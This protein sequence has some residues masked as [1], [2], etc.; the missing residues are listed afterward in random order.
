[1]AAE[2]Q[3]HRAE[4]YLTSNSNNLPEGELT[5]YLYD[6]D[7]RHQKIGFMEGEFFAQPN[8]KVFRMEE[9]RIEDPDNRGGGTGQ[10]MVNAVMKF[11]NVLGLQKIEL[12]AGRE[13]GP[14]FWTHQGYQVETTG[15]LGNR[16]ADAVRENLEALPEEKREPIR[17]DVER[18]LENVHP[19]MN[20]ELLAIDPKGV[21]REL[22]SNTNPRMFF[23]LET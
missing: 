7:D 3:P 22:L 10:K 4:I 23:E 14:S 12:R 1:M 13:N 15:V 9:I 19:A 16:F 18:I 11:C 2:M 8:Q 20:Q 21:G 6:A 17:A 5:F